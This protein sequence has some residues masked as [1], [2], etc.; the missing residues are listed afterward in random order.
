MRLPQVH[1]TVKQ[2]L[3]TY[4][5]AVAREKRISAYVGDGSNYWAAAHVRDVARLYRLALEKPKAGARW[6]AVAE[7]DVR[8]AAIAESIGQGLDVPVVSLRPEE[9]PAHFG[10]WGMLAGGNLTG[11]SA[12]TRRELGWEPTGPGMLADLQQVN[13]AQ[14]G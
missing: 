14:H 3:V 5:I 11:S 2:G 13:Y 8:F 12:I 7:E 1:D 6:H 4:C 9:A 10:W